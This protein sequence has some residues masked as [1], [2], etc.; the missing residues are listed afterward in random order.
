M[1]SQESKVH[2]TK[3]SPYY[4][5]VDLNKKMEFREKA[6]EWPNRLC[7][8]SGVEANKAEE[9]AGDLLKEA[10]SEYKSPE[11]SHRRRAFRV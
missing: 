5:N 4:I 9:L 1:I 6:L 10:G 2:K 3:G 8:R 11:L 7:Q